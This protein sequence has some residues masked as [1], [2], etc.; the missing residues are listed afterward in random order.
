MDEYGGFYICANPPGDDSVLLNTVNFNADAF[1][2]TCG[3]GY[4]MSSV[5][6]GWGDDDPIP[7]PEAIE[8][9]KNQGWVEVVH[10]WYVHKDNGEIKHICSGEFQEILELNKIYYKEWI[11]C[12]ECNMPVPHK[13]FFM[14]EA[15]R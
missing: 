2:I 3:S 13:V 9:H 6:I 14:S 1:Y 10:N 8:N 7:L 11:C 5:N 15:L 12:E 4:S